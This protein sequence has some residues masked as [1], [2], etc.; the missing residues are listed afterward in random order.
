MDLFDCLPIAAVC[1]SSLHYSASLIQFLLLFLP[2]IVD[3]TVLCVH[4]GLSPD[5]R[6]IDQIRLI[7]RRMEVPMQG[8]FADLMWSDPD[9]RTDT[10]LPSSRGAGYL[11]GRK[12]T[13]EVSSSSSFPPTQRYTSLFPPL[14]F[15]VIQFVQRNKLALVC[16]AHQLV[17]EGYKYAFDDDSSLVTVWSAPNYSYI[18]GNSAAVL[19]L[20]D[21]CAKHF[22]LFSEVPDSERQVPVKQSIPYFM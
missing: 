12:A 19:Q 7:P 2:Q 9:S 17:M 5:V 6:T 14:L 1:F 3:E 16:R 22:I 18:S 20:F 21:S 8:A 11:F 15:P 4:G 13:Q 10:F